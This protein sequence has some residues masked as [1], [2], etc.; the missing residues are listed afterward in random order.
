VH[1][2][3]LGEFILENDANLVALRDLDSGAGSGAVETPNVDCL[4]GGDLA[5]ENLGRH[6]EH[7][8]ITVHLERQVADVSRYDRCIGHGT[9]A[10][11]NF[12]E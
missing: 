2:R 12:R 8:D 6:A 10:V 1:G 9:C 3:S 5:L 7:F 4:I 11:V